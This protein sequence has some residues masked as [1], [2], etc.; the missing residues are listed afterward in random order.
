MPNRVAHAIIE[1]MVFL[2]AALEEFGF[3]SFS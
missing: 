3:Y 2:V 1:A